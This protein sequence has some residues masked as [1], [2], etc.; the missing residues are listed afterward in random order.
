[1][2]IV[3]GATGHVGSQ[4]VKG[5][6]EAGK[7]VLAVVHSAERARELEAAGVEPVVAD[8]RDRGKLG[9]VFARGNRAFLL[10]PPG[11]PTGDSNRA[12]L[13]TARS[14]TDALHGSGLEKIVVASTYG[15]Q[16]GDSIGDLS[17]LHDFE[18]RA[19]ASGIPASINRAAYYFTNLDM[20]VDA[21]REGVVPTAFPE[22]FVLPMV[23]PEDIGR[24][25]VELLLTGVDDVGVTYVEGPERYSFGDVAAVLSRL[26]KRDVAVATTPREQ[27][28][29]SFRQVGFSEASARSFAR[30]T[31]ATL[32]NP[33]LPESPW[34]GRVGLEEY[35]AQLMR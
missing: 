6:G 13:E 22:D 2:F 17:T 8:V 19:L 33:D 5:L 35:L 14:I 18:Q 30:M 25:A 10:N 15:A 4:V 16:T 28:E 9:A 12:E 24:A 31:A 27:W 29:E 23:A 34:R 26:L 20:L 21:A 1:M 3:L 11:D 32:D 7:P